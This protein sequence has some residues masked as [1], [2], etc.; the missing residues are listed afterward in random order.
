ME[1]ELSMIE[2]L[3]DLQIK[4]HACAACVYS[5]CS[6]SSSSSVCANDAAHLD[7][8]NQLLLLFVDNLSRRSLGFLFYLFVF[9]LFI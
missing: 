7:T 3:R 4:Y 2:V 5:M 6:S 1:N 9:I 8:E